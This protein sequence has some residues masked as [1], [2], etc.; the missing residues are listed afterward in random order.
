[1]KEVLSLLGK[2]FAFIT[3]TFIFRGL[4][5][6]VIQY[7]FETA[8]KSL[9]PWNIKVPTSYLKMAKEGLIS[10]GRMIEDSTLLI[11]TFIFN[12]LVIWE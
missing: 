9:L 4:I 6:Q 10:Y 8:Q 7:G 5:P 3:V 12:Q 11:M 1:M 2:I